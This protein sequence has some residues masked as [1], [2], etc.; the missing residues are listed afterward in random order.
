MESHLGQFSTGVGC[1]LLCQRHFWPV[2]RH[3]W[4]GVAFQ[5]RPL[6]LPLQVSMMDSEIATPGS[7]GQ[8]RGRR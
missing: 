7:W 3:A 4:R 6:N 8:T 2:R 5:R 1:N